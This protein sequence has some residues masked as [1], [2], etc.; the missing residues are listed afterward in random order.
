L[1]D[2]ARIGETLDVST[3]ASYEFPPA[4]GATVLS[5]THPLV[6]T[7]ASYILDSA[8]DGAE[9]ARAA[10]CGVIQ[11]A[12]I[13]SQRALVLI[14]HRFQISGSSDL[15]AEDLQLKAYEGD[16]SN[17]KWLGEEDARSILSATPVGN[18]SDAFSKQI[19]NQH[20]S[21]I[22]DWRAQLREMANV[23]AEEILESHNQVRQA[24]GSRAAPKAVSI[25]PQG[26]PDIIGLYVLNPAT[27]EG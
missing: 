14:R 1:I 22:D 9:S 15:L 21:S 7:V 23:R 3:L 27:G 26:T 11:V 17:P 2:S 24:Y 4:S 13:K 16:P 20:I 5:R 8:I 19:L 10:R 18:L 25:K 6:E 12:G